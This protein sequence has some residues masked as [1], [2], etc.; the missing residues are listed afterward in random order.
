MSVLLG[1][2]ILSLVIVALLSTAIAWGLRHF[3]RAQ[4]TVAVSVFLAFLV[5]AGLTVFGFSGGTANW[6]GLVPAAVA[7]LV[8]YGLWRRKLAMRKAVR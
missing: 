1:E 8:Y 2:L 3:L 4:M 5:S 6:I 7:G